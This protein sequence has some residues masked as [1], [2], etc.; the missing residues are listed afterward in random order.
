MN[1]NSRHQLIAGRQ[2]VK[3]IIVINGKNHAVTIDGDLIPIKSLRIKTATRTFK[4]TGSVA[5][6]SSR[7]ERRG[8]GQARNYK[9]VTGTLC[10]GRYYNTVRHAIAAAYESDLPFV[11][12]DNDTGKTA[13]FDLLHDDEKYIAAGLCRESYFIIYDGL[14]GFCLGE[15]RNLNA[16]VARSEKYSIPTEIYYRNGS[17]IWR[18]KKS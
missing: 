10:N 4:P 8:G 5:G 12:Y 17:K 3:R 2:T 11:H 7:H 6:Y 18:H 15:Y 13:V 1:T 16:A 9:R 14:Y